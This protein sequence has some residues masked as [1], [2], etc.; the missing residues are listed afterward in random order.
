MCMCM[1]ISTCAHDRVK[2]VV[3]VGVRQDGGVVLGPQVRLHP[4]ALLRG[5]LVD[6]LACMAWPWPWQGK[7][8]REEG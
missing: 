1:C 5:S 3:L 7:G 4:L 2:G 8:G 6:V